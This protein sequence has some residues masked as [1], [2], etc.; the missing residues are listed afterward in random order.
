[1]CVYVQACD[2]NDQVHK[3]N[4]HLTA[5]D[6]FKK[7]TITGSINNLYLYYNVHS[8]TINNINVHEDSEKGK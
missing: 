5:K 6:I 1:M 3:Y 7:T 4:I 8:N 2:F